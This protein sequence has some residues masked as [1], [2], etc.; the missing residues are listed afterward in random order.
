MV[1]LASIHQHRH[2]EEVSLAELSRIQSSRVVTTTTGSTADW[3][4]RQSCDH[5]DAENRDDVVDFESTPEHMADEE[6]SAARTSA[7]AH[8]SA[9]VHI[10]TEHSNGIPTTTTTTRRVE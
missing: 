8:V 6:V 2:G 10:S 3:L 9:Q 1:Y 4:I 5:K 7:S